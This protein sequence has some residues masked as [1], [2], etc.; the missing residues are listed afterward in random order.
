MKDLVCPPIIILD[1]S[2]NIVTSQSLSVLFVDES[3]VEG[4]KYCHPYTGQ[5]REWCMVDCGQ[6]LPVSLRVADMMDN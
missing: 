3:P 2:R 6:W 4:T 1:V 5:G